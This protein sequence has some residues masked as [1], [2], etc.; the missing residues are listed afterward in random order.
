MHRKVHCSPAY[1]SHKMEATIMLSKDE[2]TR[3]MWDTYAR[4]C[5]RVIKKK[6]NLPFA[7]MWMN[8][9]ILLLRKIRQMGKAIYPMTS[10]VSSS[11]KK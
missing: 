2:L 7:A 9:E 4:E 3:K 1:N 6:E 11:K 5:Y 8:P 10:L